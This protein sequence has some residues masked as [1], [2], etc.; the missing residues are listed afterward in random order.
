MQSFAKLVRL[1]DDTQA[2]SKAEATK[3]IVEPILQ[4]L[5]PNQYELTSIFTAASLLNTNILAASLATW[6]ESDFPENEFTTMEVWGSCSL[7]HKGPFLLVGLYFHVHQKRVFFAWN[8]HENLQ[9]SYYNAAISFR[10]DWMY[11]KCST[12]S[13]ELTMNNEMRTLSIYFSSHSL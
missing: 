10:L 11:T 13:T 9:A 6:D 1:G 2:E 3:L 5:E 4:R 8:T 12:A 7:Q